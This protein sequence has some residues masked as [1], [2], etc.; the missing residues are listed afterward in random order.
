MKSNI[1]TVTLM[2]KHQNI[3]LLTS[4]KGVQVKARGLKIIAI[5][6]KEFL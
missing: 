1:P 6:L 2:Y 5:S 4:D 3:I